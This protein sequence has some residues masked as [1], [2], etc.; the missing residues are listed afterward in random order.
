MYLVAV[1]PPSN[2]R[3][4]LYDYQISLFRRSSFPAALALPPHIPLAFFD[5]PPPRPRSLIQQTSFESCG[6][7]EKPPWLLLEILPAHE[8][9]RLISELPE[10]GAF[11]WYPVAVGVPVLMNESNKKHLV[12]DYP[13]IRWKTSHLLCLKIEVK[14][15]RRWWEHIEYSEIWRVKAKRNIN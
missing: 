4:V 5:T 11:E 6:L 9:E 13:V 14:N 10:T 8:L 7:I 2:I 12:D 15:P 1:V 3:R